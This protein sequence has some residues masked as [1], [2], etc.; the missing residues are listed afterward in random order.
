[1]YGNSSLNYP[2]EREMFQT[3]L[4]EKIKCTLYFKLFIFKNSAVYEIMWKN[5][6]EP[7]LP[8]MTIWSMRISRWVPKAPHT[9]THTHT[10]TLR[11][12][13]IYCFSTAI[14]IARLRHILRYIV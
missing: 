2:L 11:I 6:V 9:H 4:V 8:H 7:D 10:H 13:N 1:M 12:S 5:I 14:I 3:K